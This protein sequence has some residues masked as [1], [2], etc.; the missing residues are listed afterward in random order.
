MRSVQLS[1][2][3]EIKPLVAIGKQFREKYRFCL[4]GYR[5]V[6]YEDFDANSL[7]VPVTSHDSIHF[8]IAVSATEN[9][10]LEA[11]DISKAYLFGDLDVPILMEQP[12]VSTQQPA[13][14]GNVCKLIKSIHGARFLTA[15]SRRGDS[16]VQHSTSSLLPSR[17]R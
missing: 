14:P 12:A 8:L 2:A 16:I 1:W 17:R 7:Y 13:K 3:F 10:A 5:Q 9:F 11:A 15:T 6:A 4:R